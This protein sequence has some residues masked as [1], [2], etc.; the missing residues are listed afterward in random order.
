MWNRDKGSR[1]VVDWKESYI[2]KS[3]AHIEDNGTFACSE[4]DPSVLNNQAVREWAQK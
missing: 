2:Q 1:F 3:V 4:V